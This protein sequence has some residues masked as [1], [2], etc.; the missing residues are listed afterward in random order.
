M[1]IKAEN[2]RKNF[3]DFE[4]LKGVTFNVPRGDI[5]GF[6]GPN[7]AGKTTVMR[8]ITCFMQ[9]SSGRCE[10]LN[11]DVNKYP[12]E[13]KA[14]LGVVAQEN[15]LDPDVTALENLIIYAGYY[16]IPYRIALAKAKELLNSVELAEKTDSRIQALSG[17]MLRRLMIARSL[18]NTPEILIMDEPTTGL[19][20]HSRRLLWNKLIELKK[21]TGF[22]MIISTH[23]MEE[24]ATLCSKVAI[25]DRGLVV[26]VDTP[27]NLMDTHGGTLEDV[28]LKLTGVHLK[29]AD[30]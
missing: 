24:A 27:Q 12:S 18:V 9:A 21:A 2:L 28:Y 11:M 8:I 19:D 3:G 29:E 7:G 30:I 5:F 20:P 16:G 22:T 14:R 23:Y 1:M 4:A 26:T 6:L 13:I 15:N 25:M 10:V 17:G